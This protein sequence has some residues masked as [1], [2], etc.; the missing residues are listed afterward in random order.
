MAMFNKH[1]ALGEPTGVASGIAK[2]MKAAA[3]KDPRVVAVLEDL[4]FPD[5]EWWTE[6]MADRI[7]ECGIAEQNGAC[8]AAAL[9]SEGFT[10]VIYSFLFACIGRAYN[11]IRQSILVDRFNVKFLAR[12][13]VWSEFG[14]SHNTV[15]GI[16]SCRV[17]PNLVIM[18]P[19]DVVEAEKA[20]EAM[21]RYIGPVVVRQEQSPD[22]LRIFTD[23]YPFE[24]GKA[25]EVKDGRDATIIATGYML[26][27]AIRA[28]ELLERDGL[29]VAILDMCT[30][31][32]LDEEAIVAAAAKTGAIVTAENCSDVGGLGDGVAA[33][34]AEHLPTPVI[35]VGVEDEFSQSG[36]ITA[37][38]DELME[39]FALGAADLAI[40][41]KECIS[42]KMA[43]AAR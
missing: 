9:A 27:E 16:A 19:A 34:L 3:L 5:I 20:T 39:H 6:N 23:D 38:R 12:E 37:E 15:E 30:L 42:K 21:M 31:K 10:P 8:V 40:S 17:L 7:V 25:Y 14:V 24:I 13:G 2:A 36:L 33:V 22:P 4:Q 18:N 11:Q 26:T 43:L 28:I 41:V 32:P 35:K 29:D 1:V